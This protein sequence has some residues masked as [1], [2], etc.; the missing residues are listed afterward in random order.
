MIDC[1]IIALSAPLRRF[2]RVTSERLFL[3]SICLISLIFVSVFQSRL[4][5]VFIKPMYY[6]DIDTLVELDNSNFSIHLK[7]QAMLDDLFL[8]PNSTL[9][10]SL[11]SKLFLTPQSSVSKLI[12]KQ[13]EAFITR[14][15][16]TRLNHEKYFRNNELH[17]VEECPI[18]YN[19]GFVF[20]KHSVFKDRINEILLNL[21]NG[22]FMEKWIQDMY[23]T[24][25][26]QNIKEINF[27]YSNFKILNLSDLQLSF[28][29]LGSGLLI[30]IFVLFIETIYTKF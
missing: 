2:S 4:S 15:S 14:K 23:Y 7:H 16:S 8:E 21:L 25:K 6:K 29:V 28:C 27:Q 19:I 24:T 5:S 1:Y 30:S 26:L 12:H 18:L 20:P 10:K 3:S 17:L 11:R 13:N 22:G 9:K